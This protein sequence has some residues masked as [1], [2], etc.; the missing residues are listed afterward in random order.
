MP[1][2]NIGT[3]KEGKIEDNKSC[4]FFN[5]LA[6][7]PATRPAIVVFNKHAK[8]V[9]TGLIEKNIDIVLGENNVK[10]P[11]TSPNK[12]PIIGPYNIAPKAIKIKEKFKLANPPGITT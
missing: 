5:I 7:I 4:F 11:E 6:I 10:M 3:I 8:T 1:V 9:P 2:F 12:E